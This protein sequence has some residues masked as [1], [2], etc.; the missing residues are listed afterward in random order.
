MIMIMIMIV[1]YIFSFIKIKLIYIINL[2]LSYKNYFFKLKL[3][4][5]DF[6][7]NNYLIELNLKLFI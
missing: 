5:K 4:N 1:L 7:L 6:N 3:N 2:Y